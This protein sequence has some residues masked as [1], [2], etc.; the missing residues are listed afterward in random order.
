MD[1]PHAR[2]SG[3]LVTD[4][5]GGFEVHTIRP[6]G[7]QRTV[8]LGGVQRHIPA[9]IHIDASASGHPERRVQVV[10]SDDPL[11]DEP[12]WRHWVSSLKQPVVTPELQGQDVVAYAVVVLE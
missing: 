9:H 2:L 5:R 3:R 1:E 12:Y 11:L 4:A 6:G 7:Y 8:T 10:F